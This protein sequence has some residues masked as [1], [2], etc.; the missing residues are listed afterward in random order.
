MNAVYIVIIARNSALDNASAHEFDTEY[1][2]RLFADV[3][4]NMGYFTNIIKK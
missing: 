1:K 4:A 2:A 3:W